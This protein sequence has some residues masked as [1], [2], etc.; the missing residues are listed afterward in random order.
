MLYGRNSFSQAIHE[1]SIAEA[2]REGRVQDLRAGLR[3]VEPMLIT[4]VS[5]I[6]YFETK[7]TQ[8]MGLYMTIKGLKQEEEELQVN[9]QRL[10]G[11]LRKDLLEFYREVNE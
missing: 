10:C 3:N 9:R 11:C 6:S 4:K 7:F 1:V 2:V 8:L 5:D